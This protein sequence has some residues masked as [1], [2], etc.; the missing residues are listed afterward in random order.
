[1]KALDNLGQEIKVGD[2]IAYATIIGRSANQSVYVVNDVVVS[3][4]KEWDSTFRAYNYIPSLKLKATPLIRSYGNHRPAKNVT[5]SMLERCIVLPQSYKEL[6]E[7][8]DKN[9]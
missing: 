2:V 1:M 5:L 9:D 4:S 7:K 6:I 8:A 3:S